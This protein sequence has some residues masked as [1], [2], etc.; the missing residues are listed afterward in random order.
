VTVYLD[1]NATTPPA[2]EVVDAVVAAMERCGNPGSLHAAGLAAREAVAKARR[3]V[4]ALTGARPS[5]V[6]FT[7]GGTEADNLAIAGVMRLVA[8]GAGTLLVGGAE[9]VAVLASADALAAAGHRVRR[10]R[11]DLDGRVDLDAVRAL[12]DEAAA[13]GA[14]VRLVSLMVA[15]NETGVLYPVREVAALAHAAGALV[16]TDAVQAAAKVPLDVAALGADLLAV[17][18]HKFYGPKGSGALIVRRGVTLCPLVPGGGQERG[19]RGGTENVPGIVGLGVAA[20]LAREH[21]HEGNARIAAL[22]DRFEAELA[23]ALPGVRF[24]GAGGARLPATSS[25]TFPALDGELLLMHLDLNG[26]AAS[27]GAA[28]AS[29]E[30]EP[31][32]ALMASG[33]GRDDARR[34]LRFSFGRGNGMAD[35]DR[36][37]AVIVEVT[38]RHV[39]ADFSALV[40]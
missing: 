30:M 27:Y 25:V 33:L 12:I 34:T 6:V 17:T 40:S 4:A 22:R 39:A 15:N 26:V 23:R 20:R 2:P 24:N 28:C 35:V 19:R 21:M 10:V 1:H 7:S 5:E 3:E 37:I 9:H 14:P 13:C 29:G 11:V 18:A 32:E 38:R 16:H 8:P 36:A 31:S